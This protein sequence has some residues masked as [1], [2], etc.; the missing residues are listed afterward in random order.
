MTIIDEGFQQYHFSTPG[1]SEID[2]VNMI[3]QYKEHME[4]GGGSFS[5]IL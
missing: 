1:F 3:G 5:D 2:A 4:L